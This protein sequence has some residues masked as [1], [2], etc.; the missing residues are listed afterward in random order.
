MESKNNW[1]AWLYLAPAIILLLIFTFYPLINTIL[2]AFAKDYNIY[3]NE[4]ALGA[5]FR[6]G[7]TFDNFGYVLGLKGIS[8]NGQVL[9]DKT[10]IEYALP[11]TLII[12]FVTV[13]SDRASDRGGNQFDQMVSENIP[14]Y[15][16]HS[17]RYQL[18]R[19]RHGLR[20]H[21]RGN[22]RF[23]ELDFPSGKC[24]LGRHGRQPSQRYVRFVRLHYLARIAV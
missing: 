20:G 9:Y 19:H 3:A 2:I 4:T 21:F 12:V 16:L 7:F 15:I 6:S 24:Q 17:L 18:D 10:V 13:D 5:I 23:M 22:Q 1:K 11:N 14:D 8:L